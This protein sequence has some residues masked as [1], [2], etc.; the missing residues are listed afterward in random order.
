[1]NLA[2]NPASKPP[3]DSKSPNDSNSMGPWIIA[4][5]VLLLLILHQDN[6]FWTD[7]TLVL[8]FLPIAMFWHVC[9]SIGAALTWLLATKIAWPVDDSAAVEDQAEANVGEGQ[10]R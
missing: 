6:W 4:G 8:G 5:L 7:G 3:N 9:I 1:M 2:T 10:N